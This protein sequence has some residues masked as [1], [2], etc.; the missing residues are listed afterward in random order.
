MFETCRSKIELDEL[1]EKAMRVER[2]KR[3]VDELI[4][5]VERAR[6][7]VVKLAGAATARGKPPETVPAVV[8]SSKTLVRAIDRLITYIADEEYDTRVRALLT[9]HKLGPL[10]QDRMIATMCTTRDAILRIALLKGLAALFDGSHFGVVVAFCEMAG[11]YDDPAH[12]EA[13]REAWPILI[14]N[15]GEYRRLRLAAERA[16]KRR[17]RSR[18]H[19]G[20]D[21]P[22][23]DPATEGGTATAGR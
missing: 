6:T 15:V 17:P 1:W 11:K 16:A 4:S 8:S 13:V 23:A 7:R 3:T 5:A 12:R 20:A 9:I 19:R 10:G 2:E 14:K 22:A 21:L 18:G